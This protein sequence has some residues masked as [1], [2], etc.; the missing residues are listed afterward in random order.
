[1]TFSY[2]DENGEDV[3]RSAT[4]VSSDAEDAVANRSYVATYTLDDTD[5]GIESDVD[6][7]IRIHDR[8]GNVKIRGCN[9]GR[10]STPASW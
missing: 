10:G 4:V 5:S 1:M 2:L 6:Y 8:S 3:T 7:Q 9:G